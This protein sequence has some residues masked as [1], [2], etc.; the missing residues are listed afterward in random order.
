MIN[1]SRIKFF[2][3][4]KGVFVFV[5]ILLWVVLTFLFFRMAIA[6]DVPEWDDKLYRNDLPFHLRMAVKRPDYS[7][8]NLF[9]RAFAKFVVFGEIGYRIY[10]ICA[11][12]YL[13]TIVVATPFA[14]VFL[15]KEI[16]NISLADEEKL[17]DQVLQI[18]SIISIFIIS[19]VIPEV[20]YYY[21]RGAVQINVWQNPT[22]FTMRLFG[23]LAIAFF[24]RIDSKYMTENASELSVK[25]YVLFGLC[26]FL[27]NYAKPNFTM[28]FGPM[29]VIVLLVDFLKRRTKEAFFQT[30]R[31]AICALPTL[32]LLLWQFTMIV[33]TELN[34]DNKAVVM[35]FASYMVESKHPVLKFVCFAILPLLLFVFSY[36]TIAKM[37]KIYGRIF[38]YW[39]IQWLIYIM[40]AEIG[41][42]FEDGNF[43]WGSIHANFLLYATLIY[44]YFCET[45]Q[46]VNDKIIVA[47]NRK[48]QIFH[49]FKMLLPGVLI[50]YQTV[51]G[52]IYFGCILRGDWFFF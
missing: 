45:K 18:I 52:L 14:V 46:S 43:A 36:K 32:I 42:H 44:A 26:L 27:A 15:L 48:K 7:L 28:A 40:L 31:F 33:Q 30:F 51:F 50:I 21:Y 35:P 22:Y 24:L 1:K 11:A 13:S 47:Y 41:T 16:A 49:W 17:S 19:L 12:V 25:D 3:K 6:Y 23:T 10:N 9:F 4:T 8:N 5:L 39:I 37:K 20:F 29:F 2:L 38:M 34:D